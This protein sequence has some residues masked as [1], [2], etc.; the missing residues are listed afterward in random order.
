MRGEGANQLI[1]DVQKVWISLWLRCEKAV[2]K[3]VMWKS[4][5]I[6]TFLRPVVNIVHKMWGT[7][8]PL[9]DKGISRIGAKLS[10]PSTSLLL[11]VST[12]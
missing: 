5:E 7:F 9:I 12:L 6:L 3:S 11:L 10:T 2:G 4:R 8:T 1:L